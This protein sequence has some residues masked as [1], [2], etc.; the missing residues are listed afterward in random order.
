MF[1]N[2]LPYIHNNKQR[3]EWQDSSRG[4][5]NCHSK[6]TLLVSWYINIYKVT[7]DIWI[8][9][10]DFSV[11]DTGILQ[12]GVQPDLPVTSPDELWKT[13]ESLGR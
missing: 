11:S 8:D 10:D 4:K 5:L 9:N 3:K 1:N 13:R 2:T 12:T 7:N 6:A